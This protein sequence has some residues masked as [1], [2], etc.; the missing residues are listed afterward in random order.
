MVESKSGRSKWS[1]YPDWKVWFQH[2]LWSFV[3]F[4]LTKP[5][6]IFLA[7]N[8]LPWSPFFLPTLVPSVGQNL[9][10]RKHCSFLIKWRGIFPVSLRHERCDWQRHQVGHLIRNYC[11]TVIARHFQEVPFHMCFTNR[12]SA[13]AF[14][15]RNRV[16]THATDEATQGAYVSHGQRE[17]HLPFMDV[18]SCI[19]VPWA[20]RFVYGRDQQNTSTCQS[21][22]KKI[23]N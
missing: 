15:G 22:E 6:D 5:A 4:P 14:Y 1:E 9:S 2:A 3:T 7:V 13:Y 23:Q 16:H 10:A 8:K 21:Q 19:C 12:E 18:V 17:V 11:C 20:T